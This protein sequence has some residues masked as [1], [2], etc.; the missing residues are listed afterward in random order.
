MEYTLVFGV[1]K[2]FNTV[3]F[4]HLIISYV[5]I[6]VFVATD[7]LH[8]CRLRVFIRV[9]IGCWRKGVCNLKGAGFYE[10]KSGAY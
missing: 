3:M 7:P 4:F 6:G 9:L 1:K 8:P 5:L 2:S 10:Y